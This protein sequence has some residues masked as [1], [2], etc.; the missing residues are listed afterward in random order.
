[1]SACDLTFLTKDS[2]SQFC[3]SEYNFFTTRH[4]RS[5]SC[6][7]SQILNLWEQ[8][9][10]KMSYSCKKLVFRGFNAY[11]WRTLYIP[12]NIGIIWPSDMTSLWLYWKV[13]LTIKLKDLVT[14]RPWSTSST[15]ACATKEFILW[16]S[17]ELYLHLRYP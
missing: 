6:W 1:M 17:W 4:F 10:A 8:N 15:V 3:G 5:R 9:K 2:K 16:V 14:D 12:C 7:C 13:W 11:P